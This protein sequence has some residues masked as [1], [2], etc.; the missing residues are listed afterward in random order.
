M[1]TT[2]KH[3]PHEL[4]KAFPRMSADEL[5]ELAA[6]IKKNGLQDPI[7][8]YE[9]K[10]LDGTHRQEAC[11][12]SGVEP[13][14]VPFK[15]QEAEAIS[16]V[17][18]RNMRRRHLTASQKAMLAA[19]LIEQM[20]LAEKNGAEISSS[21]ELLRT[22]KPGRPAEGGEKTVV[23]GASLGVSPAS[24][25][26]ARKILKESPKKAK[27]IA[28]GKLTVGKATRDEAK[29]Q[30]AKQRYEAAI[31]R[32]RNVCGKALADAV[33]NGSRLKNQKDALAFADQTDAAMKA[34]QG[35]IEN[36]WT[37]KK[38]RSYKAKNLTLKSTL[39]DFSNKAA[40]SGSELTV[41]IE[42]WRFAVTRTKGGTH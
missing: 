36:G 22:G 19:K 11:A 42:G 14:Y 27:E 25:K 1:I 37:L 31:A 10:V 4:A 2:V 23:V 18:S 6:D 21:R 16:F 38:A 30:A 32:I 26:R 17:I 41:D 9:G 13:R 28:A 8:L 39:G 5:R 24:V 3:K 15:G 20:E 12:I 7:V 33:R 34:Q 35:L 29:I 40:A